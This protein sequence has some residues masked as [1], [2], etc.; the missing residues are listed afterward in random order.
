VQHVSR[1][2]NTVANDLMQQASGFQS[3]QE[4]FSFLKK[5]DGL[6]FGRCTMQQSVLLDQVQQ[7]RIVRFLKPEGPK[8]PGTRMRQAKQ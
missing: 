6:I 7:N 5:P 2:E 3:N 8:I 1:D 4:K